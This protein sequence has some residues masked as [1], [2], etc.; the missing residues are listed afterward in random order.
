MTIEKF[1]NAVNEQMKVCTNML[2]TKGKEY[3]PN[4]SDEIVTDR[5]EHFKKAAA[6]MN[7]TPKMALLGMMSKHIVSVSDMCT[8]KKSYPI[9]KWNEKITDS[10]NYL[11]ILRA[12]VEEEQEGLTSNGQNRN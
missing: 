9:D 5:L 11:L 7:T 12:M 4:T 10:I 2:V 3:A 1:N 6:I 8:D